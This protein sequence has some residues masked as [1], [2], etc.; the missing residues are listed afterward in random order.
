MRNLIAS[1]L[2]AAGC[3]SAYADRVVAM[4][5]P[6]PRIAIAEAPARIRAPYDVDILRGNGESLPTYV[7]NGR[8]YVQGAAGERYTIRVSNPT[9]RRIEAVVSVDGLDAIDGQAGDLHKRGYIVPPYGEV[10]IEGFRTSL[11]DVATFRFSSVDRSYAGLKG[12]ARNVGVIAV[13]LFEEREPM[14]ERIAV[15]EPHHGYYE[16]GR[17]H[18]DEHPGASDGAARSSAKKAPAPADRDAGAASSPASEAAPSRRSDEGDVARP[19][20]RPGLGTEFGE[21]RY[22][23]A[24]YT[25]F[26][27]STNR[28]VAIA[29]LRYNDASGLLALGIQVDGIPY[30]DDVMLRET[31]DPF[32]GDHFAHPPRR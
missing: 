15:P 11:S 31:A 24:S 32:P 29:E 9:S 21:S 2:F 14:R 4:H 12:K 20:Y 7:A 3:S 19:T 25:R 16:P 17:G 30:S 5:P 18:Y 6:T 28:P 27:R 10:N 8:Y 22:S 1:V 23:G 13:A 26:E